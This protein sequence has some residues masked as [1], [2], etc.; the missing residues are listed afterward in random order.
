MPPRCCARRGA[1]AWRRCRR[2]SRACPRSRPCC[3]CSRNG[4]RTARC[5]RWRR[6]ARS[7]WSARASWRRATCRSSERGLANRP[8]SRGRA[9][10]PAA[11]ALPAQEALRA[12]AGAA[13]APAAGRLHARCAA[14][15]RRG[16]PLR[17]LPGCRRSP[18][19]AASAPAA[20]L[21]GLAAMIPR[22]T[23]AV[24]VAGAVMIA[25]SVLHSAGV[26]KGRADVQQAW[27][28]DRAAQ[29]AVAASASEAARAEEQRRVAAQQ[30]VS[31]NATLALDQARADAA[32][33]AT[34]ARGLRSAA[35]LAAARCDRGAGDPTAA[36]SGDAASDPRAVFA[37]DER[38]MREQLRARLAEVWPELQ[39]VAEARNGIE[40][41]ELVD[42]HRPDLVFLDIRMPGLG[43]VDAAR[44]IAQIEVADDESLP[45][46]VF[47]TAYDQYAVEAFEQGAADYVLNPAE[48]ARL[49]VTIDRLRSRLARRGTADADA[50]PPMQ[51]L[52]HA[53]A[54]RLDPAGAPRRLEWIQAT[55]GQ[56]IQMIPAAE[57]LFFISDEKYTRVQ[58]RKS[59]RLN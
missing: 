15:H 38:L 56:S 46:I 6:C 27:D 13:R 18:A 19:G 12:L 9:G 49:Q 57:V 1:C 30:E 42:K 41:V 32:R 22:W 20:R 3:R 4:C 45:E 21:P 52:L 26:R 25:S 48:R 55:V 33:A 23:I 59:T 43:G 37:D 24:G 10:L 34:A 2:C 50:A 5:R 14:G 29:M 28:K 58:D 36:G 17:A 16:R 40:A 54:A 8:S 53:L 11:G 47:I 7:A 39:I 31:R 51:Q 35:A 44:R